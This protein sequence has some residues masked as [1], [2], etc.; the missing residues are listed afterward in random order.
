MDIIYN[1]KSK[2]TIFIL[3]LLYPGIKFTDVLADNFIN[4]YIQD[5]VY[6]DPEDSLIIE[7]DDNIARFRMTKEYIADYKKIIKSQYSKLSDNAKETILYFWQQNKDSYLHSVL[8]KT[9]KILDYWSKKSDK[10]IEASTEKEYWPRFNLY[11]ET[12]GLNHLY[13]SFHLNLINNNG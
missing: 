13:K 5:T 10:K 9:N 12:R 2:S 6:P 1:K 8:Y 3:P 4:C 11:E 7:F